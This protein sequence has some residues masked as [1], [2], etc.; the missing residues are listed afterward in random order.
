MKLYVLNPSGQ[1]LSFQFRAP[2]ERFVRT[3]D[4]GP[5]QQEVVYDGVPDNVYQVIHQYEHYGLIE[6]TDIRAK[7]RGYT[8][9]IFALDRP[10]NIQSAKI[11]E[12]MNY[13]ALI[14]RGEEVR[15]ISAIA[16]SETV[17]SSI[18][19]A[20]FSE[21]NLQDTMLGLKGE[22]AEGQPTVINEENVVRK[23]GSSRRAA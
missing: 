16:A 6:D 4:I 14:E 12:R 17:A 23:G 2:G 11:A 10:V 8:G 18:R 7:N 19:G 9:S 21:G 5:G 1:K 3:I 22:D 20:G 13:D 15:K